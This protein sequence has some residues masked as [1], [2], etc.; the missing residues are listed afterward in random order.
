MHTLIKFISRKE[1]VDDFLAGRLYMN[2]LDFFWNN[3]FDDQ[4][5]IFEGIICTVPVQDMTFLPIDFQSVQATDCRFRAEGYKYC[6]IL[7]FYKQE[8][9]SDGPFIHFDYNT[10]MT[11]F[12]EYAVIIKNKQEL[13]RRV[14]K[15]IKAN[16]YKYLCGSVCY[17]KQKLNGK[18]SKEGNR[19]HLKV[20]DRYFEIDELIRLG[21]RIT[22]R[23]CF[24]KDI[25]YKVQN[26]WRIS[27]YRGIKETNPFVLD[28][29]RISDIVKVV[30][31]AMLEN[32][33]KKNISLY[34]SNTQDCYYG[35]IDKREMRE[36]FYQLGDNKT[37][38]FASI[39]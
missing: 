22:K 39:G 27:V 1:Y 10:K 29:G 13:L 26:E 38:L 23:D 30:P 20:S 7:C 12:G 19:L 36:L 28:I 9:Y 25:S 32:E 34:I 18:E 31:S 6:N 15:A 3:G 5:D 17:H 2:S 21:Y 24:D 35:N 37:S 11:E 4:K 14:D 8:F 16:E 33:L